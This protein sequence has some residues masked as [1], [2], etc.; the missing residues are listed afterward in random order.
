MSHLNNC[1]QIRANPVI[2]RIVHQYCD[3]FRILIDCFLYFSNLHS[4]GYSQLIIH[5][6]IHI[7]RNRTT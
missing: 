4:K 3:S 2:S 1:T 5:F 7:N 6:R